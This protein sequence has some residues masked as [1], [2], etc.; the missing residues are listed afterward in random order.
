MPAPYR[1]LFDD[2]QSALNSHLGFDA[3]ALP[4]ARHLAAAFD[5]PLFYSTTSRLLV[6]LNRSLRHPALHA[7][8]VRNG[9]HALRQRIVERH[10]QPFRSEVERSIR[11]NIAAGRR[12]LHLSSHSFTPELEG[13]RRDA[14]I[15]LLYDPARLGERSLCRAWQARLQ[16][17]AP[18]LTVRRNYPYRGSADGFTTY[19]RRRYPATHYLGIELEI[20]QRHVGQGAKA[21]RRLREILVIGL[22]EAI[23]SEQFLG[24]MQAM[25]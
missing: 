24:A 3:G 23:E 2:C 22:S 1:K 13:V 6:D 4:L 21:W 8:N 19:L 25:T 12:I 9:P 15:G 14:D 5:A 10:Y 20:N 11:Q 17:H 7:H 16:Q 18:E